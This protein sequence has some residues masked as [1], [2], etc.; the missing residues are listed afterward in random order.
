MGVILGLS[1][2]FTTSMVALFLRC[3]ARRVDQQLDAFRRG[4][5][6]AHWTYGP[7]EWRSFAEAEWARARGEAWVPVVAV[8]VVLAII[9]SLFLLTEAKENEGLLPILGALLV[10]FGLFSYCLMRFFGQASYGRAQRRVGETYIG[11]NGIYFNGKYHTWLSFGIGL[12]DIQVLEGKP[13]VVEVS[14]GPT[15]G[16]QASVIAARGRSQGGY[17]LRVL[18]PAGREEE[19]K[20]VVER[21]VTVSL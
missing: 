4:E 6:L 3:T 13:T 11:P 16:V 17:T 12:Q 1:A 5:Y 14:I 10:V 21:I 9:S 15:E 19:A 8:V 18:V 20:K 7:D 2:G